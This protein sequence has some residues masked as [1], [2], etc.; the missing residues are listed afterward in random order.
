MVTRVIGSSNSRG[1]VHGRSFRQP[2]EKP[3]W[4]QRLLGIRYRPGS[5]FE[6]E[7]VD[8]ATAL[9]A[10]DDALDD[11]GH[12][13]IVADGGGKMNFHSTKGKRDVWI[14]CWFF[15]S[16]LDEIVI[17]RDGAFRLVSLSNDL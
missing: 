3:A 16:D 2:L 9:R 11:D 5:Y 17:T 12:F 4:W 7:A 6:M 1:L 13:S 15:D 10:L 14:D 8:E